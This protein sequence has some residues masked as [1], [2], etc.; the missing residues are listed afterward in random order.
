MRILPQNVVREKALRL[1]RA[2]RVERLSFDRFNVVGDHGTYIVARNQDGRVNC[3]C[4][5]FQSR[6]R[7][8]HSMAVKILTK[9]NA[10]RKD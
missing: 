6:R 8:S 1:L 7:C 4:P 3:T 2:E 10:N 9:R 5:G